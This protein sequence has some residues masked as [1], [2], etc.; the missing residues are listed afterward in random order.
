MMMVNENAISGKTFFMIFPLMSSP[1]LTAIN[2]PNIHSV[3]RDDG[4][5]DGRHNIKHLGERMRA[6]SNMYLCPQK[7]DTFHK[8]LHPSL[9]VSWLIETLHL[10][11]H[12]K[13]RSASS[14][15]P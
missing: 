8:T 3:P 14:A 12:L 6:W 13:G 15:V 7:A 4:H 2:T 10:I 5:T 9:K 1:R 11:A